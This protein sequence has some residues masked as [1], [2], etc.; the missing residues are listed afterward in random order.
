MWKLIDPVNIIVVHFKFN[1]KQIISREEARR[2]ESLAV[3]PDQSV[4]P[5]LSQESSILTD[6]HI[7]L[8]IMTVLFF[9]LHVCHFHFQ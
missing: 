8:V 1:S 3:D 6:Q 7:M 5:E 9:V 4:M 2:R